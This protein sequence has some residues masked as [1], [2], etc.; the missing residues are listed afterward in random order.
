MATSPSLEPGSWTDH[1]TLGLPQSESYNL[2]DPNLF[3]EA[4]KLYLTFG[5]FWM[6]IF[7]TTLPDPPI[8]YSSSPIEELL[9]NNSDSAAVWEAPFQFKWNH[10]GRHLYYLFYSAGECCKQPP[11]L[12]EK[13]DE[14]RIQVCR[15]ESVRGPYFDHQGCDCKT[16]DGGTL[17]LG[18]HDDVYAPG[19]QGVMFDPV[20]GRPVI[21]YHYGKL[22]RRTYLAGVSADIDI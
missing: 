15:G 19:G 20:I 13:G 18:S 3:I 12:A 9:N 17:V 10:R 11:D 6:D 21:Y 8:K 16:E 22:F 2:I 1:G 14:Y 5:S 4:N 7:Q